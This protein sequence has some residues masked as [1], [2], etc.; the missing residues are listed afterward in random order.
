MPMQDG[1]M[2][3]KAKRAI[4][5]YD[6]NESTPEKRDE[7]V[8]A[9]EEEEEEEEEAPVDAK[10]KKQEPPKDNAGRVA[11]AIAQGMA[12]YGKQMKEYHAKRESWR[13]RFSK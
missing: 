11:W 1:Y 12:T 8:S 3:K 4:G 7:Y 13:R 9:K 10:G 2:K 5:D 6:Y